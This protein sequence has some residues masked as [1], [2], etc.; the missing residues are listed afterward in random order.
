MKIKGKHFF[1][2]LIV[3]LSEHVTKIKIYVRIESLVDYS[4][5][6]N[7]TYLRIFKLKK[8]N[9]YVFKKS[10]GSSLKERETK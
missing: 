2:Q 6:C 7:V 10:V 3:N 9:G 5:F 4:L 8:I 1:D